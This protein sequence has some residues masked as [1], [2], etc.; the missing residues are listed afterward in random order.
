[1]QERFL[2][3]EIVFYSRLSGANATQ[4]LRIKFFEGFDLKQFS[5]AATIFLTALSPSLVLAEEDTSLS[6]YQ[7]FDEGDGTPT[8]AG[9]EKIENEY[10]ALVSEGNCSEA[11]PKIVEF[12]KAANYASNLIRRGNEP[13]Y[14][15]RRDDQKTIAANRSVLDELISA[16]RTFNNLIRQR[17]RAW[18]EE[19]KC[20]LE[21]GDK[22]GAVTRLYRA[23]DYISGTEETALWKEARNLLWAQVGLEVKG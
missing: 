16:E 10:Q 5:L 18:V 11:L 4:G 9:I 17:N 1:M 21:Q 19:A 13:Y 14:D 2:L 23:L 20:L 12:A 7:L 8:L 6:R 3:R 15:A 22:D